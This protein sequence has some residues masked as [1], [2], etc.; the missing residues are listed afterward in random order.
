MTT[1]TLTW[2]DIDDV[3]GIPGWGLSVGYT[4][5]SPR[6]AGEPPSVWIHAATINTGHRV[7]DLTTRD[8][9]NITQLEYAI[10][11]DIEVDDA[12]AAF[13]L[14]HPDRRDDGDY[15]FDRAEQNRHEREQDDGLP[16]FV[17]AM[18]RGMLV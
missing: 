3:L 13:E 10:A 6:E 15:S 11:E 2:R 7:I 14:S 16:T 17:D 12:Q 1:P 8:L 9:P 18:T 4:V 5:D